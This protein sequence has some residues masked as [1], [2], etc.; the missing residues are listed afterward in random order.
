MNL[1]ILLF[2]LGIIGLWWGAG[3]T[4]EGARKIA[5][6]YKISQLFIGLTVLSIGTS[7]PEIFTHVASSLKILQGIEASG[8]AIGTNIGSDI[9]QITLIVGIIAM[10]TT[11]KSTKDMLKR[12]G[13]VMIGAIVLL[14]IF[15]FNRFVSQLE[16]MILVI[17]YIIYLIFLT[18]KEKNIRELISPYHKPFEKRKKN[19]V[20]KHLTL[21]L[22]GV[23]VLSFASYWVVENT[24][25][26]AR[27]FGI[28]QTFLGLIVIGLS[29][30]LPE[31]TTAIRGVLRGVKTMSLGVLIGS[32]ITNPMLALG[33]GAAISGYTISESILWFDIPFKFLMSVMVILFFWHK[34]K[35]SKW[36]AGLLI[37]AYLAYVTY[38]IYGVL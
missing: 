35:L 11:I 29:T 32:N 36:Q 28:E 26:F 9:I 10:F 12:D 34:Q 38:K 37:A 24:L 23:L 25:F 33:M 13:L 8:V 16:G 22:I 21:I 31:L 14:W 4:I 5:R 18:R 19:H 3:L 17:L 30:A 1:E 2:I 20:L 15:S 27:T 6:H 7:L